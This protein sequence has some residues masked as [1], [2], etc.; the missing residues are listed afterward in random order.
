M[1]CCICVSYMNLVLQDAQGGTK[2]FQCDRMGIQWMYH[3]VHALGE[4]EP[5]NGVY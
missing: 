1:L 5:L 4:G 3:S 2:W